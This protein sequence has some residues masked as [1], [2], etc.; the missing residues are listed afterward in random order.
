MSSLEERMRILKLIESSQISAEEGANLL[1][2]LSDD[3]TRMRNRSAMRAHILRVRVTDLNSHRQKVNV[4]VPVSLIDIGIKLGARLFPHGGPNIDEIKRTIESGA[5]GR[6][7][8]LQDLDQ[9]E[10]IEIFV[11]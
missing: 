3:T 4:T 11:E 8:D 7:F 6:V 2:A 9:A 1:D 10:R 5:T